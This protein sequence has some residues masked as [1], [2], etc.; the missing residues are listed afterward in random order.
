[1]ARPEIAVGLARM[2]DV[3]EI[4]LMS[5]DL[6]EN[7]LRWSWTPRRVGASVG[8]ATT[9]VVV[10]RAEDQIAGFGIMRYGLPV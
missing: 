6:I 2:S 7:G 9:L 5:R 3:V 4:A 8:S 1:M 10:A